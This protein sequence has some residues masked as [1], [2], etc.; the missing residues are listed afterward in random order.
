VRRN[1]GASASSACVTRSPRR[2]APRD[3]HC[4]LHLDYA[5]AT[6]SLEGPEPPVEFTH[7]VEFLRRLS[8]DELRAARQLLFQQFGGV[9]PAM[10]LSRASI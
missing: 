4:L 9:D 5:F 8:A 6:K 10:R 2:G 1:P 3:D 7:T